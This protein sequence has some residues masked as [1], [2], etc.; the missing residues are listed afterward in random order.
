MKG[1]SSKRLVLRETRQ[2]KTTAKSENSLSFPYHQK[3]KAIKNLPNFLE[4]AKLIIEKLARF[5]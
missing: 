4:F 2:N 3:R 5:K 1:L